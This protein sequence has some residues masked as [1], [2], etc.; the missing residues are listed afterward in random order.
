MSLLL[1]ALAAMLVQ[2]TVATA[3]KV[4]LPALFPAA[5]AELGFD[6]QLVL[7]YTWFYAVCAVAVMV[8]CGGVIRRWGAL[9]TSQV[10]C[11]LMAAGLLAAA[12]LATPWT[13]L[14]AMALAALLGSVGSTVATPA[15][16]QILA[17]YAPAKWA[18]LV[19]SIK[20]AG[21]PAGV[22]IAGFAL[23]PLAVAFGWRWAAAALAVVCVLIGVL[24]QPL[25]A[26]FDRD[27]DPRVVPR[28]GDFAASVRDVL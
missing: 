15:S 10:G 1:I 22:A 4:A 7:L 3:A 9:R 14:P 6:S 25:R 18:P 17:R 23:A 19:F 12:W 5:A 27:R 20:Q 8:G 16:S 26:E 24:L 21:V 2:Q 13:V 28:I 11:L